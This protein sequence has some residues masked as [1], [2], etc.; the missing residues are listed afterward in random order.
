LGVHV[1][2]WRMTFA[3]LLGDFDYPHLNK[4]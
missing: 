2:G 3:M 4:K 1:Q